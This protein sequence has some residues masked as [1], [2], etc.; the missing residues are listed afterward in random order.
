MTAV[1]APLRPAADLL[2]HWVTRIKDPQLSKQ[3]ISVEMA[4]EDAAG[5]LLAAIVGGEIDKHDVALQLCNAA[6][7]NGI[8]EPEAIVYAALG[9]DVPIK[10]RKKPRPRKSRSK[11]P[12]RDPGGPSA[13]AQDK[14]PGDEAGCPVAPLGH[15]GGTYFYLSKAG[16]IRRLQDKDHK[17]LQILSL[18]DGD[19][20]WLIE[21]CPAYDRDGQIRP[22]TWS[23]EA[24]A[25][26][27]IRLAAWRG[28][29][30]PN[31][32]MRGPGVWRTTD[33]NLVAHV[34]DAIATLSP[35]DCKRLAKGQGKFEW[36][37]AGQIIDGGLYT[38]TARCQRPASAPAPW[39]AGH[40]LLEGLQ[41]WR[42]DNPLSADMILG[43]LGAAMLGGA[44][45]WR[46]HLLLIA[47]GGSGKT[48][49]MNY[50]DAALGGMGAYT[51]DTTEA[52]LRQALTGETRA[53][54]IDEAEGDEGSQGKVEAVIRLIR[55][56]SSGA[57]ANVMRGSAGGKSQN[58]QITGCAA[59]AAV[60]PP[61][62]KPTDRSRM[63][64]VNVLRPLSGEKNVLADEKTIA[65]I[66]SAREFAPALRT[67]AIAGWPRF[68][69]AFSLYRAGLIKR[70]VSAR[71]ADTLATILAG[72][73]LLLHDG[74]PD[75]DAIEDDLGRFTLFMDS[76][77]EAE[78]EGE[79][80]QCLIHLYSSIFDRWREGERL[81][82]AELLMDGWAELKLGSDNGLAAVQR[83][84]ARTGLKLV[85]LD[86]DDGIVVARQHE[87][88]KGIFKDSKWSNGRW[89]TALGYLD[90]ARMPDKKWRFGGVPVRAVFLPQ[91]HL[92]SM[93]E[94]KVD[95]NDAKP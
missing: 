19:E 51:N 47:Q 31:T 84:L 67:R 76:A 33:D 45:S 5:E 3:P 35:D 22:G 81:T 26:R 32:P 34:G 68:L 50:L 17:R 4:C 57:G 89:V 2:K 55:L 21:H 49:L 54:L 77:K 9:M 27:L 70:E 16:E 71:N 93:K 86:G 24:A 60:L 39:L 25:R 23:H 88:L 92:P 1:D 13:P 65:A 37:H 61:Q 28:I 29:F 38:A 58:F 53:L 74:L 42:Y 43:F 10:Q 20:E 80:Q 79:G 44:P 46:V 41:L 75:G 78:D 59:M 6:R 36:Q 85:K 72:R 30:D 64:I 91:T 11:R 18:F 40:D 90:G 48:R 56:M 8:E 7:A 52:G 62:L 12:Q 66:K 94:D 15:N 82:V 83:R 14:T 87:G 69:E 73:N 63:C 95:Y